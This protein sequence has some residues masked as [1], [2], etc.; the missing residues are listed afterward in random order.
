MFPIPFYPALPTDICT[1]GISVR[2]T[3]D[4]QGMWLISFPKCRTILPPK[5]VR[6]CPQFS[7]GWVKFKKQE[8]NSSTLRQLL[9]QR[10]FINH[11]YIGTFNA[12]REILPCQPTYG[13]QEPCKI[14]AS[15]GKM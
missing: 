10:F 4:A 12:G 14:F 2:V 7:C 5:A 15:T 13:A 8:S 1:N 6:Y 9:Q 11:C 3:Q